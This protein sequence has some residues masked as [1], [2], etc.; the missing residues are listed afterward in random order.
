MHLRGVNLEL[1]KDMSIALVG[2]SGSGKSTLLCLLR[3]L[4]EPDSVRV[5]CDGK[6]QPNG[7]RHLAAETTLLPQDPQ[8]FN[9]TIERNVTFGLEAHETAVPEAL[10]LARFAPVVARLPQ[11]TDTNIAEKGVNL[12]GGEKQRLALARG[13][14]FARDSQLILLDEPTRSVDTYNERL[15][16]TSVL[17]R[18][19]DKC[20]VSSIH[21]LHLLDLFDRIYVLEAGKIVESGDFHSLLKRNGA[22]ARMWQHYQVGSADEPGLSVGQAYGKMRAARL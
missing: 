7:L 14:F 18:F 6:L 17:S 8:L 10:E 19:K 11:G 1:R 3:G 21:K 5:L 16:Y 13:L 15:I 20:V 12:S 2:E 9:D 4:Q 22:L